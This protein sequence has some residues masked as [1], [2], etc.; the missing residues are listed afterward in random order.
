MI[1]TYLTPLAALRLIFQ[2]TNIVPPRLV[3]FVVPGFGA[4]PVIVYPLD[5]ETLRVPL[6]LVLAN[7]ILRLRVDIR[8]VIVDDGFYMVR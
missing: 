6:T 1:E 2:T 7:L 8:V 5:A 4:N 3:R